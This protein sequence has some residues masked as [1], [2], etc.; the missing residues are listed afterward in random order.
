MP[1]PMPPQRPEEADVQVP[2]GA[3][4]VLAL[5]GHPLAASDRT[6]LRAFAAQAQETARAGPDLAEGAA[7][8]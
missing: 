4:L 3:D 1:G 8:A 5:A 7:M 2:A 6:V